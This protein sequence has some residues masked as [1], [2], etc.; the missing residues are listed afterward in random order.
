MVGVGSAAIFLEREAPSITEEDIP[1]I[2]DEDLRLSK[3]EI[4][5][6]DNL[7]YEFASWFSVGTRK[8]IWPNEEKRPGEIK[9]LYWPEEI[10][11]SISELRKGEEWNND[12]VYKTLEKNENLL[13]KL[14]EVMKKPNL[15]FQVPLFENPEEIKMGSPIPSFRNYRRIADLNLLKAFYSFKNGEQ[16]EGFNQAIEAAKLGYLMQRAPNQSL[17]HNLIGIQIEQRGLTAFQEMINDSTL[18]V[19]E[20]TRYISKLEQFK[21][22][23]EGAKLALKFE[24]HATINTK[25]DY[26][27]KTKEERELSNYQKQIQTALEE[28]WG[29]IDKSKLSYKP[30]ATEKI[31]AEYFRPYASKTFKFYED[32][33]EWEIPDPIKNLD[34]ENEETFGNNLLGRT[35]LALTLARL[36]GVLEKSYELNFEKSAAQLLII[37]KVYKQENGALPGKLEELT[38]N[39]IEQV[40]L[41]PFDGKSI[42]YSKQKKIIYSVGEDL[43]DDNGKEEK[44]LIVE[45]NF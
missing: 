9:K 44:D 2:N 19:N 5:K 13:N 15:T 39:Y 28:R 38:P 12:L 26:L 22:H 34:V 25:R 42:R 17:I 11:D 21:N 1:P 23:Q 27:D 31:I 41:D 24:Y 43:K 10:D 29:E 14:D 7:V 16:E 30:N 4:P 35:Y 33:P 36:S 8:T 20:L 40:P 18:P 45:I 3:I 6:E 37:L 32:I